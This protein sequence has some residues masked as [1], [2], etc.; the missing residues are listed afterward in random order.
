MYM[1]LHRH[2]AGRFF[3]RTQ[4]A[5]SADVGLVPATGFTVN[6]GWSGPGVTDVDYTQAFLRCLLP[7][8]T[9]FA[10]DLVVVAAGFDAG[11]GD[12]LGECKLTPRMFALMTYMVRAFANGRCVLALEGGY[13]IDTLCSG[14]EACVR[15][16]LHEPVPVANE[17]GEWACAPTTCDA[18]RSACARQCIGMASDSTRVTIATSVLAVAEYT[19]A[20][21]TVRAGM[22]SPRVTGAADERQSGGPGAV[23]AVDRL[24]VVV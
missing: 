24:C 4:R 9:A 17:Q 23:A 15:V 16:L 6:C 14:T 1:S 21:T 5:S 22:D 7:I 10:P 8:A 12:P 18:C 19:Q 11:A 13:N 3:P 20:C 2:D